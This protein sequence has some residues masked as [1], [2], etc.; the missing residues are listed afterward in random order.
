MLHLH[1][2][3]DA[4]WG[5]RMAPHIDA[6]LL[7][8]AHLEKKAASTALTLLFRHPQHVWLQ[9]PLSELAREEL[10]HFELVLGHLEAR[11]LDF[12]IQRPAP[13]AGRLLTEVRAKEPER[14]LDT[15]LCCA[16]IEARSCERMGRLAEALPEGPVAEMYRGLLVSEAH[17][18][19]LYLDLARRLVGSE[20]AELRL[21]HLARHEAAVI[22]EAPAM[23]R[24]HSAPPTSPDP[25]A[26]R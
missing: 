21:D 13:Y 4:H 2:K 17:H 11:Q 5:E 12:G 25:L 22:A 24:L 3:T 9:R 1:T 6:V 19:V 10:S 15:L 23:P 14:L 26:A 7:D 18:H 8:H 16:L 20:V